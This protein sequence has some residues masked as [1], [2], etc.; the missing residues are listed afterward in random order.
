MSAGS[1]AHRDED[2]GGAAVLSETEI[3]T[4]EDYLELL[5][6]GKASLMRWGEIV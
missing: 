4:V 6:S 3:K 2:I 5:R 1:D